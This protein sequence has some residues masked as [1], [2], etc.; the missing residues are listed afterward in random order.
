MRSPQ[1]ARSQ[2]HRCWQLEKYLAPIHIHFLLLIYIV[3]ISSAGTPDYIFPP[4]IISFPFPLTSNT[5]PTIAS[6]LFCLFF[7]LPSVSLIWAPV[8]L[9]PPFPQHLFFVFST[10]SHPKYYQRWLSLA[11]TLTRLVIPPPPP[12]IPPLPPRTSQAPVARVT[13]HFSSLARIPPT[14]SPALSLRVILSSRYKRPLRPARRW[15][16]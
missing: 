3:H 13:A 9:T 11:L 8:A 16:G 12:I 6:A 10:F 1:A 4:S 15:S 14:S 7:L 5:S 2:R